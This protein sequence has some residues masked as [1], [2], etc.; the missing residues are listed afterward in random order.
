MQPIRALALVI[1][2]AS[3]AS[4]ADE[5]AVAAKTGP[6]VTITITDSTANQMLAQAFAATVG[7]NADSEEGYQKGYELGGNPARE[8]YRRKERSGNLTVLVNERLTIAVET[9]DLPSEELRKWLGRVDLQK[10]A[11]LQP[12]EGRALI[13]DQQLIP[14]L[15]EPPKGWTAER[16]VSLGSQGAGFQ[17]SQANRVYRKK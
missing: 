5:P 1:L 13:P 9:Q 3:F 6:R 2:A 11:K 10:L 4:A 15:P 17:I 12:G 7:V 14:H 16:A 8:E